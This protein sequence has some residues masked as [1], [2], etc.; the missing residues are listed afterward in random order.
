MKANRGFVDG[1]GGV[2]VLDR[3]ADGFRPHL[4]LDA[5]AFA[6]HAIRR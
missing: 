5:R 6:H 1:G 2:F 4:A 3:L